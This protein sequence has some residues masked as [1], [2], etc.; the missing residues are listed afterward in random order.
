MPHV[1]QGRATPFAAVL[2]GAIAFVGACGGGGG[3]TAGGGGDAGDAGPAADGGAAA[4]GGSGADAASDV[5]D[6]SA[7]GLVAIGKPCSTGVDGGSTTTSVNP[8]APECDSQICIQPA[9]DPRQSE[10]VDTAPLCSAECR[11]DGDCVDAEA[12]NPASPGDRRCRGGFTCA[13]ATEVGRLCCKRLCLC[14]DFLVIPDG[15]VP[16]PATCDPT[17]PVNRCKNLPGR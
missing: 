13:I 8:Q 16:T 6:G 2:L 10:A 5:T 12:R 17:N 14:R 1:K 9:I 15:G 7:G 4:D 3:A 11:G